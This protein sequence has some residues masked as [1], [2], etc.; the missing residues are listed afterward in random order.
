MAHQYFITA[1]KNNYSITVTNKIFYQNNNCIVS[2]I[3]EPERDKFKF[4]LTRNLDM[5]S[6]SKSHEMDKYNAMDGEAQREFLSIYNF[7][8][9]WSAVTD[10]KCVYNELLKAWLLQL[11][12]LDRKYFSKSYLLPQWSNFPESKFTE[13]RNNLRKYFAV[14]LK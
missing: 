10:F 11:T 8:Q 13:I 14:V 3:F 7:K 6:F 5:E 2:Y 4:T 1:M 9:T 12:Y